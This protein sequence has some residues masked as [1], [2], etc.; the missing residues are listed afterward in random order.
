MENRE[1]VIEHLDYSGK[2]Y[3]KLNDAEMLNCYKLADGFGGWDWSH[4]RDSSAEAFDRIADYIRSLPEIGSE[5]ICG[6][7]RILLGTLI[8]RRDGWYKVAVNFYG[9][10]R[11][12]AMRPEDVEIA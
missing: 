10:V 9:Q 4:I 3:G 12:F 6:E 8:E 7:G 5:V 2:Y 11:E 1:F